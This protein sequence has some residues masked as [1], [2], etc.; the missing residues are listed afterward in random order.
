MSTD[1]RDEEVQKR[2]VPT[3]RQMV[4]RSM[5]VG[6]W[7]MVILMAMGMQQMRIRQM[8]VGTRRSGDD[9][10]TRPYIHTNEKLPKHNRQGLDRWLQALSERTP[11]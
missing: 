9:L 7:R 8:A 1:M 10:G 11:V 3:P 2:Y 5:V 6:T 4:A